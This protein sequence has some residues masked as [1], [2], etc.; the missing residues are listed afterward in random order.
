MSFLWSPRS[1]VNRQRQRACLSGRRIRFRP[2]LRLIAHNL[3]CPFSSIADA[4]LG[5]GEPGVGCH[6]GTFARQQRIVLRNRLR[7]ITRQPRRKR[8]SS[9]RALAAGAP[10]IPVRGERGGGTGVCA[11]EG[12]FPNKNILPTF[13]RVIFDKYQNYRYGERR[14]D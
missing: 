7:A 11:G 2:D 1:Y 14:L 3:Q 13:I 5:R 6:F 9:G 12:K 8:K 10:K 4:S